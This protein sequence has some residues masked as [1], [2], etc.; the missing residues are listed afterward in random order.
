MSE[1]DG[2][3]VRQ[4]LEKLNITIDELPM[5]AANYVP[6]VTSGNMVSSLS[7]NLYR[8]GLSLRPLSVLHHT[9]LPL[10]LSLTSPPFLSRKREIFRLLLCLS[11]LL[12]SL[13]H[14]PTLLWRSSNQ[15]FVSGQ[16]P[17][18]GGKLDDSHKV[19]PDQ[20]FLPLLLFL[21]FVCTRS[22]RSS[23]TALDNFPTYHTL[24][25]HSPNLKNIYLRRCTHSNV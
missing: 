5:P 3:T 14:P 16:L 13:S 7:I 10:P 18:R 15:V 23:P 24:I 11:I 2:L 22:F 8:P 20:L 17:S 12:S 6:Y 1:A 21:V 25:T 9:S 4:R 19:S